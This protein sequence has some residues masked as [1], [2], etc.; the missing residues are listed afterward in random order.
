MLCIASR[1]AAAAAAAALLTAQPA[2]ARF[3]DED[4]AH[5]YD[6]LEEDGM[7]DAV[8]NTMEIGTRLFWNED[9]DEASR[10]FAGAIRDIELV[11]LDDK[12]VEQARSMWY[13]EGSKTFKG[14]PYERAMTY[15]YRGLT[16]LTKGDYE[17][18]R[19]AF[20][21]GQMQDAF[22]EEEQFKMDFGLL[23]YLEAWASHLNGDYELRDEAMRL[24]ADIRT[25]LPAFEETQ[26]TLVIVETGSAPR[27][28]GDGLDHAYF[29]YRRG[30]GFKEDGVSLTWSDQRRAMLLGEDIFRQASTRG[31]REIDRI[32]DGQVKF[33]A[34]SRR[35]SNALTEGAE[36]LSLAGG[37]GTVAAVAGG[38][39]IVAALFSGKAKPRADT[40]A[41][42][43]LCDRVHVA[44][45]SSAELSGQ[46]VTAEFTRG[47]ETYGDA[48]PA[49]V[50]FITDPNG[51]RLGLARS[52]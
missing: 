39:G 24:L 16:F 30:K 5:Y 45:L 17:N 13:E 1:L 6:R 22:A 44:A 15:Y 41:W 7:Q 28:L 40:R 14:E 27:K 8:L 12:S 23:L 19:A 46:S 34:G 29:V 3:G 4:L 36:A 31:G 37:D 52:R 11:F 26:D 2:A 20:R 49:E 35:V 48:A 47:G 21:Q 18:A 42:S 33:K 32:L 51:N 10:A 25:D 43:S 50:R 9:F 38:V